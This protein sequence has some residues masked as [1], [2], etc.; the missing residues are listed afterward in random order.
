MKK[1][2]LFFIPLSLIFSFSYSQD[3]SKSFFK[4]NNSYSST[5]NGPQKSFFKKQPEQPE[6]KI[7]DNNTEILIDTLESKE[8]NLINDSI[9]DNIVFLDAPIDQGYV[10]S[11]YSP[12]R[13]HP[14]L[15]KWKAH[16][17]TDFAAPYGTPIKA[18]AGGI[19]EAASF[20]EGNGNFVKIKHNDTFSTQYLHMSK[21][22]VKNGDLI[23]IGD[24]IGLVGSTGLASGPHVCYRFWKDGVQVDP[25]DIA[26]EEQENNSGQENK[27]NNASDNQD[28]KDFKKFISG[29]FNQN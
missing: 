28:T 3:K 13:F 26:K 11:N 23:K 1:N 4:K 18:T 16:K 8:I 19:V 10:S 12:K 2:I 22:L 7:V 5:Q 17:G 27:D 24:V 29:F 14:V 9:N 15:K 25:Y 20:T 6:V 21:I